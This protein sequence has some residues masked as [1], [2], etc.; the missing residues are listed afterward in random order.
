[1]FIGSSQEHV[2]A[3]RA[4]QASLHQEFE[5]RVWDQNVV[6]P[7]TYTLESLASALG[8]SDFGIFVAAPDDLVKSR[9]RNS[10][11][12]RDNVI[13][14]LGMFVGRLGID[15][16]F[17]VV[18]IAPSNVTL[19]S[20]LLGLTV[21][22]YNPV[23]TDN[24]L[25]AAVAPACNQIR[26]L[27]RTNHVPRRE[28]LSLISHTGLFSRFSPRFEQL[29]AET[30]TITT[31]FIHS[32]RWRENH[33]DQLKDFL[34]RDNVTFTVYLPDLRCDRLLA[35]LQE[36]FDDGDHLPVFI[37]DAYRY[38]ADLQKAHKTKLRV[39]LTRLHPTYSFYEFD[40]CIVVAL[41]P[42][43][44]MRRDV[45]TFEIPVNSELSEFFREDIAQLRKDAQQ[46]RNAELNRL[47]ARYK[48]DTERSPIA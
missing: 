47:A 1:M 44:A 34:G 24:D 20:D 29:I 30:K 32:R 22:Q 46:V 25:T 12:A 28:A 33:N 7:S 35:S 16:V 6:K 4:V 42:L 3:A 48:A 43:S 10:F 18:P 27:I 40:K 38:F 31:H 37:A 2:D 15:R 39:F 5:T 8:E 36:H 11:R 17:I 45:P 41:Y 26:E 14:E 19:P 23:R 13:F 9:G 21:A